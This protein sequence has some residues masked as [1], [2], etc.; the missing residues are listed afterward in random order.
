MLQLDHISQ[1]DSRI[2]IYGFPE[3]NPKRQEMPICSSRRQSRD[4]SELGGSSVPD[5]DV[6]MNQNSVLV[7]TKVDQLCTRTFF[8]EDL[9]CFSLFGANNYSLY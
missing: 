9:F 3:F 8:F 2:S 4:T 7:V 6:K 5:I 1:V